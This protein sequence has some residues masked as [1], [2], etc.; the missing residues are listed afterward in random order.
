MIKIS[1]F[2]LICL[3]ACVGR[4]TFAGEKISCG[5]M[6]NGQL[7]LSKLLVDELREKDALESVISEYGVQSVRV[8]MNCKRL[9]N[10]G[11]LY[12]GD[13]TY[14][15]EACLLADNPDE[16]METLR[17]ELD[18][19][20]RYPDENCSSTPVSFWTKGGGGEFIVHNS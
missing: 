15:S 6:V 14:C 7:S 8:C 13:I 18:D 17:N 16:D 10:E 1:E 3:F 20:F 12:C 19:E 2:D 11:W 9:M 5:K 4:C